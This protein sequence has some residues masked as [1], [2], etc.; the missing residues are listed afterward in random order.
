MVNG[1]GGS[2][3]ENVL[4]LFFFFFRF[5]DERKKCQRPTTDMPSF[6]VDISVWIW[7]VSLDGEWWCWWW[8]VCLGG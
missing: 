3:T 7:A 8:L 1:G 4:T 6:P 2:P 5:V